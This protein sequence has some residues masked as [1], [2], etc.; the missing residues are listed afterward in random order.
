MRRKFQ[1][2]SIERQLKHIDGDR[3]IKLW[4]AS[5]RLVLYSRVVYNAAHN[6]RLNADILSS[7]LSSLD[8]LDTPTD[9]SNLEDFLEE[10]IKSEKT[11]NSLPRF[12]DKRQQYLFNRNTETISGFIWE[13]N[14][15]IFQQEIQLKILKL[16][17]D[18]GGVLSD[19]IVEMAVAYARDS[20]NLAKEV[21][22]RAKDPAVQIWLILKEIGGLEYPF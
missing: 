14:G 17:A 12:W 1:R 13:I 7:S 19:K 20:D 16:A 18:P 22:N 9:R 11:A 21:G 6:R 8:L 10:N 5:L 15:H 3:H 2:E 4:T